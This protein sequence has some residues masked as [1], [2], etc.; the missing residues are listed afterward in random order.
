MKDK[1]ITAEG[2]I[3]VAQY[4]RIDNKEKPIL[5]CLD[6]VMQDVMSPDEWIMNDRQICQLLDKHC[7]RVFDRAIFYPQLLALCLSFLQ[8]KKVRIGGRF[9]LW[10]DPNFIPIG[11]LNLGHHPAHSKAAQES[12]MKQVR[13]IADL[14]E[15]DKKTRDR[16]ALILVGKSTFERLTAVCPNESVKLG[17]RL[18]LS[19]ATKNTLDALDPKGAGLL[20]KHYSNDTRSPITDL[21]RLRL[22]CDAGGKQAAITKNI[23]IKNKNIIANNIRTMLS[24]AIYDIIEGGFFVSSLTKDWNTPVPIK[25]LNAN[26]GL[27]NLMLDY[28][29]KYGEDD[30]GPIVKHMLDFLIKTLYNPKQKMFRDNH[31]YISHGKNNGMWRFE[32]F[33]TELNENDVEFLTHYISISDLEK[34]KNNYH[35]VHLSHS[36][37]SF[38]VF[39]QIIMLL[40][41]ITGKYECVNKSAVQAPV[42]L[43]SNVHIASVLIKTSKNLHTDRFSKIGENILSVIW[44]IF[45]KCNGNLPQCIENGNQYGHAMLDGYAF[46]ADALITLYDH[47]LDT[48]FL[49]QA[50]EVHASTKKIFWDSK[51]QN[52]HICPLIEKLTGFKIYRS[53]MVGVGGIAAALRNEVRLC[54]LCGEEYASVLDSAYKLHYNGMISHGHLIEFSN[55]LELFNWLKQDNLLIILYYFEQ[56][57][58][59]KHLACLTNDLSIRTRVSALVIDNK[60]RERKAKKLLSLLKQGPQKNHIYLIQQDK[61]IEQF[62]TLEQFNEFFSKF[63]ENAQFPDTKQHDQPRQLKLV[64]HSE[65]N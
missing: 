64:M 46:F 42:S 34:D 60:D 38:E 52:F 53:Q 10:L 20:D 8:K 30:F 27:I 61:W 58:A 59:K 25:N 44:S 43:A 33:V 22:V 15:N 17:D 9:F 23:A 31:N 57:E 37:I 63:L 6:A 16:K 14:F 39:G 18:S 7:V 19:S 55:L 48:H 2:W 21:L 3:N 12:V 45:E 62:Q 50:E 13:E 28:H 36:N 49:L 26:A 40:N 11:V 5:L 54:E 35:Y 29:S 4:F 41:K 56:S 51:T 65:E 32:D 24:G 1:D 47:T